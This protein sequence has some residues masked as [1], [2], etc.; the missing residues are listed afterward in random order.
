MERFWEDYK[1]NPRGWSFWTHR[2]KDFFN[3]YVIH[4]DKGY[5]IKLDSIY[6]NNPLGVGTEI[7]VEKDQL[8]K[9][10]PGFGFRRFTKEEIEEF[11]ESFSQ[12]EDED[13]KKKLLEKQ[14]R[15]K[16]TLPMEGE[17]EDYLMLGPFYG[18]SPFKYHLE[19]QEKTD[20]ELRK[21]LKKEFRRKYPMYR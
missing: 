19:Q 7:K 13:S 9:D 16:P 5:F 20:E 18:G 8:E 21:K 3:I 11:M 2:S 10:L 17:K 15:K 4:E 14:I 12:A 6:N 1:E